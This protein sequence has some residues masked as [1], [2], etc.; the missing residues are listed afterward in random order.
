MAERNRKTKLSIIGAGNV[1]SHIAVYAAGKDLADIVLLDQNADKAKGIGL[2]I[3][4]A[5]RRNTFMSEAPYS[6]RLCWPAT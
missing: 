4:Q 1:G 2:D 6:L 3:T 5:M